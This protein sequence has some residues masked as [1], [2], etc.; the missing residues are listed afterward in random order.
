MRIERCCLRL[1]VS[2]VLWGVW[3]HELTVCLYVTVSSY[4]FSTQDWHDPLGHSDIYKIGVR[5]FVIRLK[6]FRLSALEYLLH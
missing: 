2:F 5:N 1:L 6:R 4:I 3:V